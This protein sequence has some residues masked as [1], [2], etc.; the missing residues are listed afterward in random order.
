MELPCPRKWITIPFAQENDKQKGEILRIFTYNLMAQGGIRREHFPYCSESAL[1]WKTR[2]GKLLAE[3]IQSQADII[4]FQE[5][6]VPFYNSFWKVELNKL[7]YSSQ[8][9]S[10]SVE[11]QNNSYG[12]AIFYNSKRFTLKKSEEIEYHDLAK[13]R[14]NQIIEELNRPNVA[15]ILGLELNN[16]PGKGVIVATTHLFWNPQFEWVRIKQSNHLL[17]RLSGFQSS[18][19][20]SWPWIICGD[21][22]TCPNDVPYNFLTKRDLPESIYYRMLAPLHQTNNLLNVVNASIEGHLEEQFQQRKAEN[23]EDFQRIREIKELLSKAKAELPL[24]ISAYQ[25]YCDLDSEIKPHSHWYGEP[26]YSV[27]GNWKGVLDYIF[28]TQNSS[29]K[30]LRILE[31]PKEDV[32]GKNVGIPSD[33]FPSDHISLMSELFLPVN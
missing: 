11:K 29:L 32:L 13:N 16:Y 9:K 25:N 6:D 8:F 1:K 19:N 18:L 28:I 4:C 23:E 3:V 20:C 30:I 14:D 12:V 15:I 24:L 7:N 2:K 10:K 17:E 26:P 27:F 33:I 5:C 22:N 21:F 31:I